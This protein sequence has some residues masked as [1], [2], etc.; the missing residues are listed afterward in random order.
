MEKNYLGLEKRN[1]KKNKV[2]TVYKKGRKWQKGKEEKQPELHK[3][4]IMINKP[5]SYISQKYDILY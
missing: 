5:F 1:K 4:K 2:R 3:S